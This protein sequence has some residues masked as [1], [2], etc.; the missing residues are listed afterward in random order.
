MAHWV[1][2]T[3]AFA[4][5]FVLLFVLVVMSAHRT[6]TRSGNATSGMSDA[7]GSFID[8]FDPA[9][10]RAERDLKSKQNQ[11]PIIPSPDDED[12]PIKVIDSG[13]RRVVEIRRPAPTQP[14]T[15]TPPADV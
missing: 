7:L 15:A 9:R 2:A 6:L 12:R 10:A 3:A 13:G 5:V 1:W 8:V 14:P 11:G 4:A